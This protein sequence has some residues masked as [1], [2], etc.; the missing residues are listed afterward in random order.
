MRWQPRGMN[1]RKRGKGVRVD[2]G[3][4]DLD[5]GEILEKTI[6]VLTMTRTLKLITVSQTVKIDEML[7]ALVVNK[8]CIK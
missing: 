1:L 4:H 2:I 3:G 7:T 6:R 5:I 8:M